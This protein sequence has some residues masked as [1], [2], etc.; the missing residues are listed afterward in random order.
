MTAHTPTSRVARLLRV[1]LAGPFALAAACF[2]VV[3]GAFWL[4]SGAAQVN[5]LVLPVLLFPLLWAVLFLYSCVDPRLG[6]AYVVVGAVL[7]LNAL[8]LVTHSAG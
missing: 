1:L 2:A 8:L 4:P 5:N 7:A 6:R 3:G